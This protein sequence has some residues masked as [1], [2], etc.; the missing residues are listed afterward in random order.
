MIEV[1]SLDY[2]KKSEK[3][4][5]IVKGVDVSY[6]NALRRCVIDFV[7]TMA[8]EDVSFSKNTSVLYDEI[9]SHRLGLIALE[10]DLK[11]YNLPAKCK[12]G[13]AGCAR[14]TLKMVLKAKGPGTVYASMIKSK[15][16]K[17]KPV[18]PETSIVKLLKGQ[19]LELEA[20]AV[21]GFGKEHS[22]WSPGLAYYK[23]RP[24]IELLKKCDKCD[25]CVK[26][27]PKKIFELEAG[28]VTINKKN[29][30]SCDLCGACFEKCPKGVIRVGEKE[31]EFIFYLESWGQLSCREIM[32]EAADCFDML[33]D[34]VLDKVK[35]M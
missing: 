5:F 11:T 7:P 35:E 20:T 29:L 32:K 15:D 21:L 12:C 33:L 30:N 31:N 27:C 22:K 23:A 10:T 26:E 16:P 8:I 6:I 13:G 24:V 18:F 9:I 14:C 2:D 25:I 34:E 17:V 19:E 28:S 3:C 4:S 1:N